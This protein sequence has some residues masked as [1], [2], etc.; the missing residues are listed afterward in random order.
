MVR[1][2]KYVCTV[3]RLQNYSIIRDNVGLC[4]IQSAR[5]R[6]HTHTQTPPGLYPYLGF[7]VLCER[8]PI[9]QWR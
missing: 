2:Y 3:Y 5:V 9:A 6:A 8:L 4:S 1:L 7:E